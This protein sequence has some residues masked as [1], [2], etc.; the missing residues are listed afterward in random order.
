MLGVHLG[1]YVTPSS[2]ALRLFTDGVFATQLSFW[3][4]STVV[5]PMSHEPTEPAPC[6]RP[7]GSEQL[8]PHVMTARL[9]A[10]NSS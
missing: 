6:F 9:Q 4:G 1:I 3:S 7:L 5:L 10:T 2:G 8:G